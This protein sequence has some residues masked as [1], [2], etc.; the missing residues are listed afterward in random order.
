VIPASSKREKDL[1]RPVTEL[2]ESLGMRVWEEATI[3]AGDEGTKTADHVAW[4]WE[5]DDL[6]AWAVEV[7]AGELSVGLAQAVAYAVGFDKVL[8]AAEEP[9]AE[10][11]YMAKVLERL[12]LGYI[13]VDRECRT[14]RLEREPKPSEFI[15]DSVR[16]ENDA[17]VRLKHLFAE[18]VLREPVRFGADRRGDNWGVT[19]TTSEWQLCGQV[20]EGA[21]STWLSLLAESKSVGDAAAVQLTAAELA[22]WIASLGDAKVV[23]QE[24]RHD[25]FK[26]Y[27]SGELASWAAS[28]SVQE[29]DELLGRARS[30]SAPRVGPHFQIKRD[31]WPHGVSLSEE[32][33]RREFLS[34]VDRFRVVQRRL[35]E[36]LIV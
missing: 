17:R 3:R 35:N 8:V 13:R 34:T 21:G 30:L 24:R 11:G 31:L 9:V 23:L 10:A 2:L 7:K 20:I 18:E 15:S 4:R 28:G 33:A 29:L 16:A 25:G 12:G 6:E 5:G 19:G 32:G 1:Y 27:Y 14:A 22:A 36:R 26:G